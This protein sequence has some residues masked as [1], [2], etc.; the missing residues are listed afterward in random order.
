MATVALSRALSRRDY[1]LARDL[2]RRAADAGYTL[3]LVGGPV[4]DALLGRRVLDLDVAA[5]AP[6]AELASALG[7]ETQQPTRFGTAKAQVNGRALD[8]AMARTEVYPGRARCP[9]LRPAR[10]RTTWADATSP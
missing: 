2:G 9:S 1:A 10:W 6:I 5:E 4:R 3:W 7:V 8:L